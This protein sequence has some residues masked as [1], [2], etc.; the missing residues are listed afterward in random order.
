MVPK[1]IP[2]FFPSNPWILNCLSWCQCYMFCIKVYHDIFLI[3]LIKSLY[4]SCMK[5]KKK[6]PFQF[7][8]PSCRGLK[9]EIS[10]PLGY[11]TAQDR[12]ETRDSKT[13]TFSGLLPL[14]LLYP[15]IIQLLFI[16]KNWYLRKLFLDFHSGTLRFGQANTCKNRC[17]I[18]SKQF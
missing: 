5:I 6:Y 12:P 2:F 14:W 11:N 3:C 16:L 9:L 1:T 10:L 18:L 15:S 13:V 8:F 4:W 17:H 7:F